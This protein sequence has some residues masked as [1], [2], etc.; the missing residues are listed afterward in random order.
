MSPLT[1]GSWSLKTAARTIPRHVIAGER[2]ARTRRTRMTSSCRWHGP[3]WRR[4][5]TAAMP[6]AQE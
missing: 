2:N 1:L 3:H 4:C 5:R 6:E